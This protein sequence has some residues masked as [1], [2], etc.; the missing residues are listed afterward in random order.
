MQ[1][2]EGEGGRLVVDAARLPFPV[3]VGGEGWASE[4]TLPEARALC[5]GVAR[6]EEQHRALA[7]T[8][9]P[10]EA[11]TLEL[12]VDLPAAAEGPCP[13]GEGGSLW[14]ELEGDRQRWALRFVLTP[15]PGSRAVEGSWTPAASRS[16]AAVLAAEPVLRGL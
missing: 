12:E 9:M 16:L 2:Q 1:L 7:E 3:L 13:P 4:L 8:L 15:G 11:I 5:A 14:L 6:L 10:E